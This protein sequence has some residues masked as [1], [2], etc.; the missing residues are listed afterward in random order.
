MKP[1]EESVFRIPTV[2]PIATR[3]IATRFVHDTSQKDFMQ[4]LS[5]LQ[6]CGHQ[7]TQAAYDHHISYNLSVKVL[8][9]EYRKV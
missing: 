3:G 4:Q 9:L 8:I 1:A 2:P 7:V 6:V 5:S